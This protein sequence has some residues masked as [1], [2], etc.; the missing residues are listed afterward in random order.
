[1]I[2][3]ILGMMAAMHLHC[4]YT[5]IVGIMHRF[6]EYL[7]TSEYYT[8]RSP[9]PKAMNIKYDILLRGRVMTIQNRGGWERGRESELVGI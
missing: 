5:T 6:C 9:K 1:M 2:V 7:I 3:N 4:M 8:V